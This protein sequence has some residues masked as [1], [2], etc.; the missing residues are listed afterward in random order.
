MS[1][2]TGPLTPMSPGST[3]RGFWTLLFPGLHQEGVSDPKRSPRQQTPV[4]QPLAR[5]PQPSAPQITTSVTGRVTGNVKT[6]STYLRHQSHPSAHPHHQATLQGI[7]RTH[8][9]WKLEQCVFGSRPKYVQTPRTQQSHE[10]IEVSVTHLPHPHART[11]TRV[12]H[13]CP[14]YHA[15]EAHIH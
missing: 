12:P 1:T 8:G 2:R 7:H 4:P 9:H 5:R 11:V 3:T 6:R 14:R 10:N 15:M 13:P